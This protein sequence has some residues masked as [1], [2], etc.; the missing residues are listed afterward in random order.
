MFYI[1][2]KSSGFWHKFNN[3]TKEIYFS[4]FTVILDDV[5]QS[6][7]IQTPNGINF[8]IK[9]VGISEIVV[10][11]ETDAS[12][13]ETF[14]SV[15]LLK[16]RLTALNYPPFASSGGGDTPNIQQVLEQGNETDQTAIF[17]DGT[18]YA[19]LDANGLRVTNTDTPEFE[20]IYGKTGIEFKRISASAWDKLFGP[21]SNGQKLQYDGA[22]LATEQAV[23]D[24]IFPLA[25]D[26][27]NLQTLVSGKQDNLGFTPENVANKAT[28]MTG[29]TASNTVYLS[30]KAIFDWVTGVGY[31]VSVNATNLVAGIMRL[32]TSTGN[33]TDGTMTQKAITDALALKLNITDSSIIAESIATGANSSGTTNTY[34]LGLLI[35]G[36]RVQA[37]WSPEAYCT[38]AKTGT[39]GTL[40]VRMYINT[41]NNLSGSPILIAQSPASTATNV[42]VGFHRFLRINTQD[43]TGSGTTIQSTSSQAYS[44]YGLS[45]T[46]MTDF[47]IDWTTD[48][49]L[50]VSVQCGN[51]SDVAV[52]RTIR[53]RR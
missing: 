20:T 32:Y 17:T 14:A 7:T 43:G 24:A 18:N 4:E 30:A 41:T 3:D 51:A 13:E 8:P 11:D 42:F 2:K 25:S 40:T 28:T 26:I 19:Y 35:P 52:C 22:D 5:S 44:D 12:V 50:I 31:W 39:S 45:T 1:I 10:I 29:N 48:K 34:S 33:N 23:V 46:S 27:N 9:G 47:A 21:S 15:E 37:G 38:V 16:V 53:F 36:G 49:Y 6:F